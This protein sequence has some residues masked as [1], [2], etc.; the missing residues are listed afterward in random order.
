MSEFTRNN[1][2]KALTRLLDAGFDNDK[3][4]IDLK[5]KDITKLEGVKSQD[6][7]IIA[8]LQSVISECKNVT[9]LLKYFS[10]NRE[11]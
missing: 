9:P 10:E 7:L 3:A 8:E 11:V 4:I 1:K 2:Y 6:L 5:L